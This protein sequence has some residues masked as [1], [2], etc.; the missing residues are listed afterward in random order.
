MK[1]KIR[2]I[3]IDYLGI[4]IGSILIAVGLIIFL[5]PNR[6]AAGGVSGLATVIYYLFGFPVGIVMLIIN[7]PLFLAGVK[8][9]G[10]HVGFRTLFG[11][12]VLSLAT[13]LL[14][15]YL[16]VLT[17]DPLLA[18]LYGGGIVGLGLGIVFKSRGTTGGTDLIAALLHHFFPA[19]SIGQGLLLVDAMVIALA[20]I[21]FNAELALYAVLSIFVSSKVI[22]LIQEGLNLAKAVLI[23]SDY[24]EEIRREILHKMDRGV[25][26]LYGS[27]GYTGRKKNVLLVIV[28]RSEVTELKHLVH[29]ID[30]KSFVIITEVHEVMGEGFQEFLSN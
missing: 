5:I 28:T 11:I 23:I 13:D 15:P 17:K 4:V 3:I 2:Q 27:G 29:R 26:T 9:L 20:G 16:P 22:D 1:D 24:S 18:S 6:I 8:V 25:T 7:I 12:V 10:K 14:T 21:V 30:P 19:F